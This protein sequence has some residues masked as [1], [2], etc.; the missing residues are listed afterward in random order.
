M[1]EKQKKTKQQLGRMSRNKGNK[2]ENRLAK[3]LDEWFYSHELENWDEVFPH[4]TEMKGSKRRIIRRTPMSGGWSK[5][6]DLKVD[7][8]FNKFIPE[9]PFFV[10]AKDEKKLDALQILNGTGSIYGYLKQAEEE[11]NGKNPITA[12]IFTTS[13]KPD[14]CVVSDIDFKDHIIGNSKVDHYIVDNHK[15]VV[16]FPLDKFCE[17]ADLQYFR[18]L[19]I[20]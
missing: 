7:P 18:N 2:N 15:K 4:L 5:C 14:Y 13:F 19:K 1:A 9:F 8:E 11:N 6:G 12:V 3:K 20:A 16:L 10:E 17:T